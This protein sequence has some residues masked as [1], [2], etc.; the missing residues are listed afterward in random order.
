M[1]TR[2]A[3]ASVAVLASNQHQKWEYHSSNS[4]ATN[5]CIYII[6]VCCSHLNV[7][8]ICAHCTHCTGYWKLLYTLHAICS[9]FFQYFFYQ[10]RFSIHSLAIPIFMN[11]KFLFFLPQSKLF[12]TISH[13]TWCDMQF[14]KRHLNDKNK[15]KNC[16]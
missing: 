1:F 12:L 3:I 15:N 5:T 10:N 7:W 16:I 11:K 8:S 4:W 14:I 9:D 6:A 2:S 13:H